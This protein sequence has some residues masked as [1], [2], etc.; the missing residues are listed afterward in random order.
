LLDIVTKLEE[1]R[2]DVDLGGGVFKMRLARSGEGKSGGY[3]V[4]VFFKS[5]KRTFYM[6]GFAK[7]E[8]AN[9]SQKVLVKLKKQAKTLFAM[10]EDQIEAALKE[11]V[12][13][14]VKEVT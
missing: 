9:I 10:T 11:G 14:E 2:P 3:R 7:S 13:E 8:T 5:G 6:H 1:G 4:M 12:F